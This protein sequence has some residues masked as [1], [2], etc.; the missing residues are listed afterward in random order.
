MSF[1][2]RTMVWIGGMSNMYRWKFLI[3]LAVLMAGAAGADTTDTTLSLS[4][5][6][7]AFYLPDEGTTYLEIYYALY[8]HQL[9]FIGSEE[10]SY[11]YAGVLVAA[12]VY[13][14][15][16]DAV[17]STATYFLSRVTDSSEEA[18]TETRLFDFLPVKIHPGRYRIDITAIDDVSKAV[19]RTS[20]AVTVPDFSSSKP[21]ASD[22]ELAYE[23]REVSSDSALVANSR[24]IKEGLLV[25]PNPTGIYQ[26]GID[27]VIN[28]YSELYGLDYSPG[29]DSGFEVRYLIKDPNGSVVHDYGWTKYEKP[30]SSAVLTE[31]LDISR[32]SAGEYFL[33]L[34]AVDLAVKRQ[35][36]ATRQ[37]II[38]DVAG[39]GTA[40][41]STSDVQQMID[42]A[43]YHLSEAE[44][45]KLA[46]LTPEGKAN[47]I[48]QF[49]RDKDDDP[50]T[51]EN[52]VYEEAVRRFKYAND[53]FSTG[54]D[55]QNGWRTDRG[56]V[57]ITYGPP[58]EVNDVVMSGKSFPYI[59]W[60]FYQ[61][62]GG[63]IFVFVNDYVAG[64]VD[65]RLVHSTHPHEK[66]DLKWKQILQDEDEQD[67]DWERAGDKQF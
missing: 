17:D 14:E 33:T 15:K 9:G 43:Y 11:R 56:R 44:K 62:A 54:S 1:N 47:L 28:V 18:R 5:S 13:N 21:S 45:I 53:N 8:R 40:T 65:Y 55:L 30:G 10:N 16:G 20:L 2:L 34:E 12:R 57:Y 19:G 42:I 58:D 61:L 48:R 6:G 46:S 31:S 7:A 49:W 37:M 63:C 66:Y 52:P 38:H 22:L 24:L 51:P 64:A 35:T 39:E 29:G 59:K 50:S 36:I 3:V 67:D 25:V 27:S 23:I 4:A 26:L 32:V 60:T 41:A